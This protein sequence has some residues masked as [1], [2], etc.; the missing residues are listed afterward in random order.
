MGWDAET[1]ATS[2]LLAYSAVYGRAP[3]NDCD[4]QDRCVYDPA[5]P[6]FDDCELTDYT[7]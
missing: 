5:C 1:V 7:E 2:F 6:F 4:R 3:K